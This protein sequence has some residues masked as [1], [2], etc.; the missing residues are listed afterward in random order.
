LRCSQDKFAYDPSKWEG[1]IN[2]LSI[3][4]V[5]GFP[6][7][8]SCQ[9]SIFVGYDRILGT[10]PETLPFSFTVRSTLLPQISLFGTLLLGLSACQD[11]TPQVIRPAPLAQDE[12]VQ[13]YMNQST[14]SQ[15]TDSYRQITRAGDD[16]EKVIVDSIN[17]AQTSI[18]VAVQELRLPKIAQAVAERHKAGIKIRVILENTYSRP[19]SNFAPQEIA[20]LAQREKDRYEEARKLIDRNQDSQLSQDEIDQWDALVILDRAAVPRIDDTEDGSKGSALMHHKFLVIDERFVIATSF[21]F[22][23]SDAHGDLS[24]STSRGNANNLVKIDSVELAKLFTEEFNILWGDGVG[25]KKDSRFGSKKPFRPAQEITVGKSTIAVQFSPAPN[26]I[27]W[28]QSTNGLIAKTLNQSTQQIDLALFV[29]SDQALVDSLG[30]KSDHSIPIRALIEPSFMYRSYSESLDMLGVLLAEKCKIEANNRPW[31]NPI[32]TVGVPNLPPGDMLHHKFGVIDSKTVVTG[33]HNW[34][35]AANRGND[36]TLLV[37]QNPVVAAHYQQEFERLY[38]SA[39]LGVPPALKRKIEEQQKSCP[40]LTQVVKHN[41]SGGLVE[42]IN[43]NTATQE[44]LESLPGVGKGLAQRIVNARQEK[45]FTSL[46]DLD[47]VPGIGAKLLNRLSDRV[48]W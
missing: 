40:Q 26:S 46:S 29:F 3:S 31:K 6:S 43:L 8:K 22:T 14:T 15:Y 35:D 39:T 23:L 13:V 42:K 41:N 47:R 19:F 24:R 9:K 1:R 10:L 28:E 48:T 45:P 37:I 16:L 32:K 18:D 20:K 36:E 27:S 38:K 34:T 30:A 12:L 25:G 33:S 5:D 4:I 11:A 21:N 17:S 44:E 7:A 2:A